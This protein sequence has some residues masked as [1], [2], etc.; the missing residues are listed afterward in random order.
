M[1]SSESRWNSGKEKKKNGT[2]GL[3]TLAQG[4]IFN[5]AYVMCS[6]ITLSSLKDPGHTV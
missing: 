5:C 3:T 4:Y 2:S 1:G 6:Y